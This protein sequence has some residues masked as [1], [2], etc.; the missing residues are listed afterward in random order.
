MRHVDVLIVGAG[1]A[2]AQAAIALR[3]N[4]YEG[5]I[6]VIGEEPEF[7]YERPPL[8]K[9]YFAG[10]KVFERILIRPVA[11]WGER[12]IEMMTGVRVTAVDPVAHTVEAMGETVGYG[13][14]IWATGGKPRELPLGGHVLGGVHTCL[15]YTSPSPRD[16]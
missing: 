15:L 9:E 14:L 13:S 16:S 2:G 5:S 12:N 6:C 1:H 10:D 11:F 7:P 3:Q 8:S 4:K